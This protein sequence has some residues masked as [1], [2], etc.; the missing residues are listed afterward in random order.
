MQIRWMF[1]AMEAGFCGN[2][3]AKGTLTCY[4]G[5]PRHPKNLA[6]LVKFTP[7]DREKEERNIWVHDV[8]TPEVQHE[9]DLDDAIF[10]VY[11]KLPVPEHGTEVRTVAVSVK[12]PVRLM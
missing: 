8:P 4:E 12:V 11:R 5:A 7:D 10:V 1:R 9:V 2:L 3:G 6:V